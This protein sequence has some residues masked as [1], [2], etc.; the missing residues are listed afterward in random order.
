MWQ[1]LRSRI[2]LWVILGA[3][4]IS[5]TLTMFLVGFLYFYPLPSDAGGRNPSL[6]TVIPAPTVTPTMMVLTPEAT[7]TTE[8]P[9]V[10]GIRVGLFVQITGTG[11]DGLR[12]RAGPGTDQSP[13]FLGY[14]S[15]VF[16]VKDGPRFSGDFVWW[17]LEAPYD[18]TRSGWAVSKYLSVVGNTPTPTP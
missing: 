6:L 18:P 15:E 10:D 14:E 9:V 16:L 1:W 7:A 8:G 3:V 2:N 13:R 4:A 17:Y 12:L 11:G 5:G